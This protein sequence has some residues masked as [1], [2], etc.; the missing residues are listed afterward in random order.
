MNLLFR[1]FQILLWKNWLLKKRHFYSTFF[2]IILPLISSIMMVITVS[3]FDPKKSIK[4]LPKMI[5]NSTAQ[6]E[7]IFFKEPVFDLNQSMI[8]FA[9]EK[10]D[11]EFMIVPDN[12]CTQKFIKSFDEEINKLVQ[13]PKKIYKKLDH[14]EQINF[15]F[16]QIKGK[17]V[18]F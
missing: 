15:Q 16:S 17:L 5:R 1:Q 6:D 14:E 10:M 18:S 13:K 7:A 12:V 2:E 8:K 11:L 4:R 9:F 3:S